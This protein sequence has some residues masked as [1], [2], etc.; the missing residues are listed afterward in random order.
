MPHYELPERIRSKLLQM[1]QEDV[2]EIIRW[3]DYV[4]AWLKVETGNVVLR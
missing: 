3:L 2:D 4:E 1:P